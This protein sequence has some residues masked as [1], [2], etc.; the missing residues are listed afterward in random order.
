M[1]PASGI[2]ITR[3]MPQAFRQ[4][5]TRNTI[6]ARSVICR[7]AALAITRRMSRAETGFAMMPTQGSAISSPHPGS[8]PSLGRV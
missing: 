2:I 7:L 6:L 8:N 4:A 3:W 5:S 1:P